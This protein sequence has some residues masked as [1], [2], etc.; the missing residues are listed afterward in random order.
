VALQKEG[1]RIAFYCSSEVD[2][3]ALAVTDA[4]FGT[5]DGSAGA[6]NLCAFPFLNLGDVR[7]IDR[8]LLE[9]L[10]PDLIIGGSPCQD[11]SRLNIQGKGLQG[12]RS[13]LFF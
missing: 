13:G 7:L 3:D 6:D 11:L 12:L 5:G 1:I 8:Q 2:P 4:R 10:Q 9:R